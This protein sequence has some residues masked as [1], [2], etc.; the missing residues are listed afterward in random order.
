MVLCLVVGNPWWAP[1]KVCSLPFC[2]RLYRNRQGVTKGKTRTRKPTPKQKSKQAK[3]RKQT[4]KSK[5]TTH[6][7]RP[8]LAV[9]L[10][11]LAASWLPDREF[12]VTGDS[13]YGGASV[14]QK[15][16]ENIDEISHVHP[17]GALYEPA[18]KLKRGEKQVGAPR[19]KGKRL[20]GMEA[21]AKDKK[22]K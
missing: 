12:M 6:R 14:L 3:K 11:T 13:A 5:S 9:E 15:L 10:L 17:K 4:K 7:T 22:P 16:P 2:F 20:P 8:E 18:P 19:K 21:W 1:I